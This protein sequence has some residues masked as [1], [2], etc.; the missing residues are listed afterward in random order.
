MRFL[1]T[2]A[3]SSVGL[4][5]VNGDIDEGAARIIVQGDPLEFR[6]FLPIAIR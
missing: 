5:L 3:G 2:D 4:A 1:L 6:R